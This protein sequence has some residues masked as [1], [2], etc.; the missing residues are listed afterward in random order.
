MCGDGE[1][2]LYSSALYVATM[3]S[4]VF[5]AIVVSYRPLILESKINNE[6]MYRHNMV[7]LYGIIICFSLLQCVGITIFSHLCINI[8]YGEAYIQS[9]PMLRIAIWYTLFSY[10]GS[11]RTVW[12]LAES[13][14]RYL[15]IIS[16]FGMLLNV[17]LNYFFIDLWGGKGAA[18]ATVFTQIFTNIV[19]IYLIKPLRPNI[20]YILE[21]LHVKKW[22]GL[23]NKS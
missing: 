3:T 2:G 21:S 13:K 10:I 22:I 4:F 8:L 9:V 19:I 20:I 15:W 1:V 6:E 16:F 5:N 23:K 18:L 12:I 7:K 14:Q 11:V 17:L